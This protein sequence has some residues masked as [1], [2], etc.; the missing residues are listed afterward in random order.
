MK[1]TRGVT[2]AKPLINE[3]TSRFP[4]VLEIKPRRV[5]SRI[6][7]VEAFLIQK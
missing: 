3:F 2:T 4:D 7:D 6:Q 1:F 5:G